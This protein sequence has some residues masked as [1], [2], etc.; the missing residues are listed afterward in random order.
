MPEVQQAAI[1]QVASGI[2][3]RVLH[4]YIT[5]DFDD[6]DLGG[7]AYTPEVVARIKTELERMTDRLYDKS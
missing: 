2:A 3:A 7:D 6:E 1:R 5:E 4:S